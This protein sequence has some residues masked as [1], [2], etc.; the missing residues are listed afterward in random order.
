METIRS[1][2]RGQNINMTGLKFGEAAQ[3]FRSE[4][5]D[6]NDPIGLGTQQDDGKRKPRRFVLPRQSFVNSE[7]NVKLARFA[8]EV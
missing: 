6:M 1:I 8:N 5:E 3:D 4:G 7:K 2:R